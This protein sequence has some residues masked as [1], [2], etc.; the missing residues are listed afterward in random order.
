MK[1]TC[2]IVAVSLCSC[3]LLL[4]QPQR[5]PRFPDM[6]PPDP[7]LDVA[8]KQ[9]LRQDFE[10][11]EQD[12][13]VPMAEREWVRK[14]GEPMR[15]VSI[16]REQEPVGRAGTVSIHALEK[17]LSS[18]S[19]KLIE[20]IQEQIRQQDMEGARKSLEAAS[21][22]DDARPY[23]LA[24]SASM[25]LAEYVRGNKN[26][27]LVRMALVELEEASPLI[28]SDVG[29]HSN[30]ALAHYFSGDLD[31]GLA[32]ANKALQLDPARAKTRYVLGVILCGQGRYAEAAFH[33]KQ[34]SS[35]IAAAR[36]LLPSVEQLAATGA[37]FT[38]Q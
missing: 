7:R 29:A 10:P 5:D 38:K 20:K 22:L 28:P 9:P 30:L 13:L 2:K 6:P 18:K 34:A 25:R 21:K 37:T 23:A 31:R 1:T 35:E 24:I 16:P 12:P 27:E 11:Q 17:P 19:R 36:E 4:A 3:T 8:L 33:L 26:S 15:T 32:E 14:A